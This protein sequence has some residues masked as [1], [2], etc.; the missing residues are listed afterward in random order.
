MSDIIIRDA[1]VNDIEEVAKLHV[2]S[3]RETYAGIISQ[4]Y[5]EN[6]KKNIDKRIIRMKNEFNLRHMIVAV[7]DDEI[8]GFSEFVLSNEFSKD[9]EIDCELCGLYIKNGYKHMG[10]GSKIFEYVA[11]LFKDN[12]KKKMGVWCV[13]E[14]IPAVSFYKKKGGVSTKEK[15]FTIEN[16]EYREIA[17]IFELARFVVL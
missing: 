5:L 3:W 17:F 8:V 2:D 6:I 7:L 4:N 15:T 16:Q 1:T 9:L 11:K 10:L 12:S 13:K 14:N